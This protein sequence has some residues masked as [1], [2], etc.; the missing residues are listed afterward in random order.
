MPTYTLEFE[1]PIL[2]LETKI[3]ELKQFAQVEKVDFT[4]EIARL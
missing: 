2:E 4:A 3:Q 1:K